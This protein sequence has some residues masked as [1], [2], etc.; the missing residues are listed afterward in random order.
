MLQQPHAKIAADAEPLRGRDREIAE[1][2]ALV[3]RARTG[4][5][6]AL[7][8]C[9]EAG[10]GKTALLD[11]TA[12][13]AANHVTVER[14]V[15]SE[16]EMEL[17]YAGLQQLCGRMMR[18]VHKL[19]DPQ[20]EALE[21]AFGLREAAAPSPFHVGLAVLGLLSEVAGDHAVVCVI[22]DAQWL[23]EV[24]ALAVAFVARRLD[25]EGIAIAL[26]MRTVA[27]PFSDLPRLA[28]EGLGDDDARELLRL[29]LP[30]AI[31]QRVRDQLIAEARGNPLA[32]RELPRALNP[33]AVA[34]GFAITGSM[35]LE[36]RIEKSLIAQLKPLPEPTRLLLKLAAAD[37]TGDPGLL[38]AAS[39]QLGL[40]PEDLDPAVEADALI[41]GARVGFRHPLVRS[42][43]YRAMAPE[44]RR[45]VHAALAEATSIDRDPDRRAWHRGCATLRPDEEVAADLERSAVRARTRGG[46]A[47]AAAFLE[48][49]AELS[50]APIRRADRLIA[51]AEAKL[52][53]GA[54]EAGLRLLD[55][56]HDQPLTGL[57]E[58]LIAR[59]R[60]RAG[61]ALRRDRSGP[62]ELLAAAQRLEPLDPALARDTYMDALA[63][64]LFGG[65]LG[66][67]G[68]VTTV[69][70]AILETTADDESDRAR[71][72]ILR[73]QALLA[74]RGLEAAAPTLRRALRAFLEQPPDA[75]ELRWMWFGCRAA[76]DLWDRDALRRLSDRQVELSRAAGVL[77]VLP[78][79][80][81]YRMAADL[82]DGRLDEFEA[83]CDE[84]DAIRNVTGHQLPQYGRII[85]AAYRGRVEEVERRAPQ[86]RAD[87]EARG[88]GHALSAINSSAAI[89]YNG[90]GRYAEALAAAR[91]ELAHTEELSFAMRSLPE[92]VEAAVRTGER[93]LAEEALAHLARVTRATGGDWGLGVL[94][95]AEAQL[96]DGAEA[97][98]LHEEAIE[99]FDRGR[100]P[101]LEGRA[102]LLYGEALRREHRRVDAREQLREAHELLVRCG[103]M[104]FAE[105][106]ARELSATG[107][108]VRARTPE[109][110][111]QL[112]D[113]ELNV[114]RLAREG[115]TNRDI[116]ARLF[117][118]ARTAEYHLR[119]VFVKLGISSRAELK[120]AL[121]ELD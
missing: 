17:P 86:F 40:K 6:G 38:W 110:I 82:L 108:T 60:A 22:D 68:V 80:L 90:A 48:R 25:V 24:S 20:R 47:A 62:R 59:L 117:I 55:T 43:V 100:M 87:A 56:A 1:L 120:M 7:V 34:G 115:L 52:E 95:L 51:A 54:P 102:R 26:G 85:V 61:Y 19:P 16:S 8:V 70:E 94:A 72:L 13:R 31:D 45:R 33:A 15:A 41:V 107:E 75:L 104:G 101:L 109:T 44:D 50:P 76:I 42:A 37:P 46:A 66:D 39:A 91:E 112:T 2:D 65:R 103:A 99:H 32:L 73:G 74:A 23:D 83:A 77:T 88:E 81:T 67:A 113:Q 111:D 64:A 116:G 97:G 69:A 3:S 14:M 12:A 29:A 35:P 30:G 93:E 106:A 27:E 58:A 92:V 9:G 89:A 57:Q 121:A 18:S 4:R 28:V 21:A 114:A 105:R 10:V 84:V 11:H 119:K 53:A 63:A 79:A 71:D 49:A 98:R 78:V 5:S 36:S 118:S 96:R